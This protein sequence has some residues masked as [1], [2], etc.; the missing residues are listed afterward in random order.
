[1]PDHCKQGYAAIKSHI[2][3]MEQ[4]EGWL[5]EAIGGSFSEENIRMLTT[6]F[7]VISPKDYFDVEFAREK[8]IHGIEIFL[9]AINSSPTLVSHLDHFPFTYKDLDYGL[10]FYTNEGKWLGHVFILKGNLS[11]FETD[12]NRRSHKIHKESF[13]EALEKVQSGL[14]RVPP[15]VVAEH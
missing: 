15:K 3:E 9:T 14:V 11:Y 4:T 10:S 7:Q 1:M 13:P 6:S 8:M 12:E 5:G 2:K